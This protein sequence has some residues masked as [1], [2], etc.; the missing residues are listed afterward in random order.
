MTP[1]ELER[2]REASR[3]RR[4][5]ALDER[6]AE[7]PVTERFSTAGLTRAQKAKLRDDDYV[8]PQD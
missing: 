6:R 7:F 4:Q 1:E 2:E 8:P 3:K 5:K